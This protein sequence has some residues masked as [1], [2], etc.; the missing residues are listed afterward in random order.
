[1]DDITHPRVCSLPD[2]M[3][4][5]NIIISSMDARFNLHR[6]FVWVNIHTC[7]ACELLNL[8]YMRPLTK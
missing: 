1:M 7:H 5:D 6:G 2:Q 3:E 4:G 8:K